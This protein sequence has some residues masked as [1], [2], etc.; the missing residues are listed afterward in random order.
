LNLAVV[1][2]DAIAVTHPGLVS[3]KIQ[4]NFAAYIKY[5]CQGDLIIAVSRQSAD[6][7]N[8]YAAREGIQ[9]PDLIV[10]RNGASFPGERSPAEKPAASPPVRAICVG[11]IDPRKNHTTLLKALDL[12]RRT[13]P[14]VDLHVA[15]I[16]NAYPGA[17]NLAQE[18]AD[19]CRDNANLEWRQG[20][21][22]AELIKAYQNCHFTLFPS[23]IE[24]FGIPVLE[25]M[26]HGRPCICSGTGAVGENAAGGGC[27][28]VDV[29]NSEELADAILK[30]AE[31]LPY[32][33]QLTN[34][35]NSRVLR[36]WEDQAMDL[37]EGLNQAVPRYQFLRS[38]SD[39]H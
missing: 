36:T 16:G 29:T 32:R 1:F 31:D 33:Q 24:G 2:H 15:L 28:T 20:V 19:A 6:E 26:W 30:M 13:Q 21:S 4:R 10:C 8:G 22:D 12:I 35:A 9:L 27:A 11:T 7:L 5:L 18:V 25:S 23:L 34:E 37:V 17:E 39:S 3:S 38:K 14:S